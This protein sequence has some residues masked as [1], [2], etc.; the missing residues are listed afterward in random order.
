MDKTN[1][2]GNYTSSWEHHAHPMVK[3]PLIAC[4]FPWLSR[5]AH[6]PPLSPWRNRLIRQH[7]QHQYSTIEGYTQL[8]LPVST[9]HRWRALRSIFAKRSR[10][11]PI[12]GLCVPKSGCCLSIFAESFSVVSLCLLRL[13]L[14]SHTH[15]PKT[16]SGC[17]V[18]D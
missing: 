18:G 10:D 7:L 3:C 1:I 2:C 14:P 8:F 9:H 11:L 15:S 13:S 17:S 4:T 16:S 5:Y 12:Q 6:R